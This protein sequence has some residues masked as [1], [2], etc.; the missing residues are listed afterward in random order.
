M[1]ISIAQRYLAFGL[2]RCL[3]V[4]LDLDFDLEFRR[5]D[6]EE[7]CFR[8]PLL[9]SLDREYLLSASRTLSSEARR[10]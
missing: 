7:E 1:S 2:A 3:E 9:L 6:L 4:D 5:P 8:P 10:P